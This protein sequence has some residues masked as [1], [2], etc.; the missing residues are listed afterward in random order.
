MFTSWAVVYWAWVQTCRST[1]DRLAPNRPPAPDPAMKL[2][3]LS[4]RPGPARRT[5][6]RDESIGGLG[7]RPIGQ[8]R[9]VLVPPPVE[10]PPHRGQFV[11]RCDRPIALLIAG[12]VARPT[13]SG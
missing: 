7:E 3:T 2:S 5:R 6:T 10:V 8:A 9:Q 13:G 11:E 4:P 1:S 12:Q